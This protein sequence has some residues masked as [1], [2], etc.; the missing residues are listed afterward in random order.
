MLL[1]LTI[2]IPVPLTVNG[3]LDQTE[4]QI[5]FRQIGKYETDVEFHHVHIPIQL[6]T[7][8]EI[9]DRAMEIIDLYTTN[10]Y[11]EMLMHY[12]LQA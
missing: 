6:G 10:I 7:Q 9:A 11:K 3:H 5:I 1:H 4:H 8:I 12:E 2:S